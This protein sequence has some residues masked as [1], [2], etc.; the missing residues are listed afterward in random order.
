MS[1]PS[2]F[3]NF[4]LGMCGRVMRYT[5]ITFSNAQSSCQLDQILSQTFKIRRMKTTFKILFI[6]LLPVCTACTDYYKVSKS[7]DYMV[8]YGAAKEMYLNGKYNT[9]GL[10]LSEVV[11]TLKGTSYGEESLYLLA[12]TN[13]QSHDYSSAAQYFKKY[14]QV[15]PRGKFTEL[16]QFYTGKSL[17]MNVPETRLDQSETYEA[18]TE[19]QNFLENYPTSQYAADAQRYIFALQDK[20]VEK[21]YLSAKLYYDLGPYFGN[22]TKGGGSNYLACIITAENAIRDFPYT[23]R[24]EDLAFLILKAKF[25]LAEQSVESKKTD[26]YHDAIDEYYGFTNEYPESKFRKEADGLFKKAKRHVS[27]T[28]SVD[29][30]I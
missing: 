27:S 24:R 9:A 10:L 5:S 17:Y 20:L 3:A 6:L 13:Y 22:Y 21:E 1:N 11:T 18:V 30:G 23:S 7:H 28:D 4:A 16:A 2:S 14:Y 25:D 19:L 12:M 26:R 15:Y 8:K 29:D